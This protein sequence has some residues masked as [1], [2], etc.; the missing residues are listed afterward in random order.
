MLWNLLKQHVSDWR[1]SRKFRSFR[2]CQL[3]VKTATEK[4]FLLGS[5]GT[6]R[7]IRT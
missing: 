4:G 5:I 3:M 1:E 7:K 6:S 2:T